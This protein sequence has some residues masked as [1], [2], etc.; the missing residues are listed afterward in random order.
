MSLLN[1]KAP[2]ER[3]AAGWFL[4]AAVLLFAALAA[5]FFAQRVYV[6][7]DLGE[8]HLPLRDFYA[9]QLAAGESFDWMPSLYG[10]FYVAG[11]GQLGAYHPWHWIL[12]QT[13]P[14]GAAFNLEVLSSYPWMF[15]GAYLFLRRLVGRRDA[16]LVGATAFT[17]GGFGLLHFIHPNAIAVVAHLPWLLWALDVVLDEQPVVKDDG[18]SAGGA[19]QLAFWT[20]AKNLLQANLRLVAMAAIGLLTASQLLLGY[21]Q[22]VWFTLLAEAGFVVYL[23]MTR[24]IQLGSLISV[25]VAVIAGVLVGAV[26]WVPTWHLLSESVRRTPSSEFANTGSLHP[27]NLVQLIAPYLFEKRV[28]GQN[29]HELGLYIGAVPLA[30]IVWLLARR[31]EWGEYR[32]LVRGLMV[33]VLVSLLLAAGEFGGLYQFQGW[34]PVVNRFRFPCRA[35]VLVQLCLAALAAVGAAVLFARRESPRPTIGNQSSRPLVMLVSASVAA[36]ILAPLVWS[37]HVANPLL[38]WTGPAAI[39]LGVLSLLLV[40]RGSR[41]GLAIMALFMAADL[42]LYGLSYAVWG[43]TAD[44]HAFVTQ[45]PR[46]PDFDGQRVATPDG[47]NKLRTGDRMLLAGIERVDGYAGLEPAKLLD[48][49]DPGVLAM[50]GVGW[51]LE[52]SDDT[53]SQRRWRR[54][55]PVA[56]RARLISRAAAPDELPRSASLRW[57]EAVCEPEQTLPPSEPGIA[58]VLQDKPGVI[59]VDATAPARQVLATTESF[60]AG[61]TATAGGRPVP[62]VRVNGDF[63][64]CVLEPGN[65]LVRLEFRPD[66]RRIGGWISVFGLGLLAVAV[67]VT[68][69]NSCRKPA[70]RGA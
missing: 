69:M 54:I 39:A 20:K 63:L 53:P 51:Q 43:R 1:T 48:Y 25:A 6:A 30:L 64:G 44:L 27:L 15:G 3:T 26:Q 37:D 11:E 41:G 13:L 59:V 9:R 14:L 52:A 34:L 56:P 10:G 22:Y 23:A 36:A 67:G 17:F 60:D 33:G 40:E 31:S 47:P 24:R 42:G 55:A 16:A 5:P 38:V 66:A 61:W 2:P 58:T 65:H 68:A 8:F 62:V 70:A 49:A 57:N 19:P 45:V 28:V 12:Y 18:E 32:P 21:P 4:L 29:T 7:D 50:A 46:P 35:I